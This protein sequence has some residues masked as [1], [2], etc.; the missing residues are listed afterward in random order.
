MGHCNSPHKP[1][2]AQ[3]VKC[4]RLSVG[5]EGRTIK[6]YNKYVAANK[7]ITYSGGKKVSC[8]ATNSSQTKKCGQ[9]CCKPKCECNH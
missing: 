1:E 3:K 8:V 9:Q 7:L 2:C 6:T 5:V 4:T